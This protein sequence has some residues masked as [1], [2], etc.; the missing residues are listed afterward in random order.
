[1]ND[2]ADEAGFAHRPVLFQEALDALAIRSDGVYLDGTYGRGG[3]SGGILDRLGPT[4]RLIALDRD[5]EAVDWARKQHAA[6]PRFRIVHGAFSGVGAVAR[7]LDVAGAL[8]GILLDLGVSSPQLDDAARGFSFMNDGPLD[9]RMNRTTGIT[10][11]DWLAQA[12]EREIV[13][14]L[15]DYGEERF[16]KRIAH[17]L[18]A[19]RTQRPFSTTG[20][21]AAVIAR[22]HPRWEPGR[23][24]ATRAF[25]AIRI[26]INGELE[27]LEQALAQSIQLL[28]PGGRLAVIS[29]HSLEDRRVK[30]FMR[31]KSA[32]KAPKGLPLPDDQIR[33]DLTLI[34]RA[35]HASAAEL[36]VNPRARSAVLRVAER[37]A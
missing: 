18:T 12:E 29:F 31:E 15:R 34:G 20:H 13:G 25:Q 19:E 27:E 1:M 6:D 36:A 14:V 7:E 35:T 9:M 10:A 33:R 32:G 8:N 26:F 24:P 17:A 28:A 30:R 4:G 11:A 16:A 22:A 23:H 37:R 5:A 21:L 3:H 2:R